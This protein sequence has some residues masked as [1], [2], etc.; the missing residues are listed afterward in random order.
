MRQEITL[1]LTTKAEQSLLL[2]DYIFFNYL[3]DVC[4]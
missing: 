3:Q 2:F 4:N 1:L